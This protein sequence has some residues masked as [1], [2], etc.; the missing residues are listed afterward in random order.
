MSPSRIEEV[1]PTQLAVNTTLGVA[2]TTS[3]VSYFNSNSGNDSS[4]FVLC[5]LHLDILYVMGGKP[6]NPFQFV[7]VVTRQGELE[8]GEEI[9][10]CPI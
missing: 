3:T 10:N 8:T 1:N 5:D 6:V 7:A 4:P 2:D 9:C